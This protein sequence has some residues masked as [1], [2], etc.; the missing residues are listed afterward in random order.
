HGEADDA[1]PDDSA[2][3]RRARYSE[4][5]GTALAATLRIRHMGL[6]PLM[7][8]NM[9]VDAVPDPEDTLFHTGRATQPEDRCQWIR[10]IVPDLLPRTDAAVQIEQGGEI[11]ARAEQTVS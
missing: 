9:R 7:I 1:Q 11:N 5:V 8:E 3:A 6:D 2:H 10:L 4:P